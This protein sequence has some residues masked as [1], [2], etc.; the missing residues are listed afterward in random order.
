MRIG[1]PFDHRIIGES[2]IFLRVSKQTS[3]SEVAERVAQAAA[4]FG[5]AA[6]EIDTAA[7]AAMGVN[8]TDLRI[9]GIVH[10]VGRVSAGELALAAGLSP[11]ATTT[12]VQRLVASG[13]LI[14]DIDG[15]DRRR[16]VITLTASA[17]ELIGNA[18]GPVGAAGKAVL[19]DFSSRELAV[20]ERFLLVG[21]DMQRQQAIRIRALTS[22]ESPG[23]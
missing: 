17:V 13:H 21:I 23:H 10:R 18:Y 20:I 15:N 12:A 16:T 5:A 11:A 6:G 22:S 2:R 8:R 1:K 19:Q 3:E 4:D 9:I 14:R 7:A